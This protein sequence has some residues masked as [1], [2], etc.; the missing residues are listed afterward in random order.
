MVFLAL[1]AVLL[2]AAYA[3]ALRQKF[4]G[5]KAAFESSRRQLEESQRL[6]QIGNWELDLTSNKLSWS[7]ETYR[8]FGIDPAASPSYENF[9]DLVHPDDRDAVDAAYRESIR[10][11]TSYETVHRLVLPD[12]RTKT[13]RERGRTIYDDKT[14]NPVRSFG[15]VQDIS[16]EVALNLEVERERA[17]ATSLLDAAPAIVLLLDNDGRIQHVNRFFESLSGYTLADVKGQDWFRTMLPQ[18]DW[19]RIQDVFADVRGGT[20]IQ[21]NVNR[22]ITKNGETFDIA[23]HAHPLSESQIPQGGVLAV[24][25]DVTRAR[26]LELQARETQERLQQVMNGMPAWLT[27]CTPDGRIIESNRTSLVMEGVTPAQMQGTLLWEGHCAS[28]SVDTRQRLKDAIEAAARGHTVRDEFTVWRAPN[29]IGIVD[30]TICPIFD[31]RGLVQYVVAFCVDITQRKEAEAAVTNLNLT[32]TRQI[33]ALRESEQRFERTFRGN[34]IAMHIKRLRDDVTIDVNAAFEVLFEG[35]RDRFI[36]RTPVENDAY[37]HPHMRAP[38]LDRLRRGE[39]IP[40]QEIQLRTLTGRIRTTLVTVEVIQFD[41]E[42][43]TLAS[44][45]DV[46][47]RI[48]SEIERKR[49]EAQLHESTKLEALGTFANGIAHDF[50]NILAVIAGNTHELKRFVSEAGAGHIQLLEMAARRGSDLVSRISLFSRGQ[51]QPR[52]RIDLVEAVRESCGLLKSTLPDT[53]ELR[54]TADPDVPAVLS[55]ETQ[56]QQVVSNLVM[57]GVHAIGGANG[58]IEICIRRVVLDHPRESRLGQITPGCYAVLT[59]TDTGPG[60][61]PA[62][63][64]RIFEPFFSTRS[65]GV[66]TG[67]G[68]SVV[69]GI[70]RAHRGH[71]LLDSAVTPGASFQVWLPALG[72]DP[73][74]PDVQE[75]PS[76]GPSRCDALRVLVIEDDAEVAATIEAAIRARRWTPTTVLSAT[77]ALRQVRERPESWDAVVTDFGMPG[78]T[79]LDITLAAQAAR[80]TLPVVVYSGEI[81]AQVEHSLR[82]AG[83]S[84]VLDKGESVESVLDRVEGAAAR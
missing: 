39:R 33:A 24:G 3:L 57:N 9:L 35:A 14:G 73:A 69:D 7:S 74:S 32:L 16:R 47:D 67:L 28:A 51:R 68:L 49:L 75:A 81:D 26:H 61:A 52:K 18:D 48:R 10:S 6:A 55:D 29:L 36:G 54:M 79:G 1:L 58:A 71:L 70:V 77:E 80:A 65:V 27:V 5:V 23:W 4:Q 20:F 78:A 2:L 40:S 41:G 60:V 12:G 82:A 43:C 62:L 19:Q 13:L 21:G 34:P 64:H 45:V 66:G 63:R 44:F 50:R 8:I 46:T 22:I 25:L 17:F 37:V 42:P 59:V 11:K 15:T 38:I 84:A 31:A 53:V 83:A 76:E 72:A 56:V 30:G